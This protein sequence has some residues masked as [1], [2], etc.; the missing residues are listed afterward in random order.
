MQTWAKRGL[1]TA[2]VTGGLLMLGT[3]I[4]SADENVNPDSPAGPLD[5][6]VNVPVQIDDNAVG[7]PLGQ[8]NTPGF[9]GEISTD[10][11]TEPLRDAAESTST[12]GDVANVASTVESRTTQDGVSGG[13]FEQTED[14]YKGNKIDGD[15]TV[16]IQICGNAL[17]VIDDASVEGAD[18]VQTYENHEDTTTDGENSGLAGN[19][20]VLDWALPVQIAGNA[21]GLAGGS[22]YASG[23][24]TQEV[25]ETGNIT[26][27]G[28]GSGASGNVVA[29]QFAT[30]VQVTGNAASWILANAYSD[31]D[32]ETEAE[33]GGWIKT[34]GE[35][36]S[37]SGNVVGAPI[38]LP[39]KF[40]GN[41]AGAWGSDADSVSSSSAEAE[42]SNE[43]TPGIN[44]IPSYIQTGGDESF[45]AGNIAQPQGALV[46]NVAGNAASW[47]G[48][49]T[50]GN[51]L[52]DG[53]AGTSTSEV[54]AGGFSS[55]S[56]Q[57]SGG[58]G[59]IADVPVGLPAE[60]FGVGGTYIGNSHA[61]HDVVTDATAGDGTYTNGDGSGLGGNSVHAPLSLA[62]EVFGIGGSHI[63]NASGTATEE[64]TVTTGGYNGT[65][66]NDSTVGGNLVQVPAA[67]PVEVFG[68][69][70]SYIGQGTG[71]AA[72]TKRIK[73]GGPGNTED[74]DALGSS[75]LVATP[76][77]VPVQLFGIG[78]SHIGRGV[79][80]ASSDT[81]TEAG[82]DLHASGKEAGASG[83]IGTVPVALPV[84][85]HGIGGSFI[86]TGHGTSANLTD[87]IAGGDASTD[88]QEGA[89]SGNVIQAPVAGAASVFGSAASWIGLVGGES[90][91]DIVAVAG[92]D[93]ETNGDGGGLAGNVVS[94]Q[95][96]PI[97]QVF[98]DAAAL[99]AKASGEATNSTDITS[100]G[101]I[102]TSAVE[103]GFSGNILDVPAAAVVQVFGNAAAALGVADA[104][105]HNVTFGE[106]GGETTTGPEDVQSFSGIDGQLPIG[107]LVQIYDVPLEL[108]GRA[109]T[110]AS[111]LTDIS[112]AG[113]EPQFDLPIDGA[114]LPADSLPSLPNMDS[115]RS[116]DGL[117]LGGSV[118]RSDAPS[119]P[120]VNTLPVELL[121]SGLAPQTDLGNLPS[122]DVT[123]L[124]PKADLPAMAELDNGPLSVFEEL[125]AELSD[126]S[127]N[128]QG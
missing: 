58:S 73:A 125:L 84:Q 20:V 42:A 120:Q 4:A 108:L 61:S 127:V 106:V 88:G 14:A 128:I 37:A 18:C 50:T 98:G 103:G 63:G 32:A 60:V 68:I 33:S 118:A 101:D 113:E 2:L 1:Q 48:N 29:G 53:A 77:S 40:N 124:A 121:P 28:A 81:I 75:N 39:V 21:G 19:A 52:G 57:N 45:L 62:P 95:G 85:L 25:T 66:G 83:N 104:E 97:A 117:P 90:T 92:G 38:A 126:R 9:E 93:T 12:A 35:G 30:P 22:G 72:E 24:A 23:T 123:G 70:G 115:L 56:G 3:G 27:D 47:I 55:T 109:T 79:G 74:D 44:G 34:D 102:E 46:A 13:S 69:G 6:N 111:N 114:E 87:S 54:E 110:E 15:L 59:N 64:K 43:G 78:G 105:G 10:P 36:G 89:V 107:A 91:N 49:A 67:I 86:G 119:L 82:G 96:L 99:M 65:R 8:I 17:G 112:V 100:G 11:I 94:A 80:V 51:A 31:F 41:A 7:T 71:T 76:L 26:T 122:M 116:M 16:P 5:L